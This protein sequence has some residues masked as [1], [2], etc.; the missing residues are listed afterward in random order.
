M[1]VPESPQRI[2][3]MDNLR[4]LAMLAGVLFHA[5]LAYSPL[6]HRYWLTADPSNSVWIDVVAWFFHLFRMPL[7]FVVAGFFAALLVSRRGIGGMLKNRTARVLMPLVIFWPLVYGSIAVLTLR[8]ISTVQKPS[9]LLTFLRQ[10]MDLPAQPPTMAHLWFLGYLMYFCILVWVV[11]AL[12]WKLPAQW[13]AR[14]RP[15]LVVGVAPLIMVPALASVTAPTPAPE[16]FLPQLWA[17]IF[18]GLY[19]GFGYQLYAHQSWMDQLN[20]W[21]HLL[22]VASLAA[23]TLFLL[24]LKIQDPLHPDPR[25]HW[26]QAALESYASAWMTLWSLHAGK[27]WCNVRNRILRYLSDA[28]YWVYIVHLPLLFAIQYWLLDVEATLSVKLAVS[29]LGV[30]AIAFASYQLLV[31]STLVGRLLNGKRTQL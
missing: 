28:S 8:A 29:V 14:L 13:F 26:L 11:W 3:Y 4:A 20:P 10:H 7:F 31:R 2:H 17:L 9:P 16:S 21:S 18:F 22:L 6:M 27:T 24:L 25:L 30:C 15:G 23:Y 12:E 1:A 5:A 19:F